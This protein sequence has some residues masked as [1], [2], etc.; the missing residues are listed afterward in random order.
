MQ[1]WSEQTDREDGADWA[2]RPDGPAYPAVRAGYPDD[3]PRQ[4]GP[5]DLRHRPEP[6]RHH[7]EPDWQDAPE[8]PRRYAEADWPME[9]R[10]Q[11]E[12]E[13]YGRQREPEQY[14]RQREP[15]QY[16]RQ[17]EPDWP[18]A[19]G[20]GRYPVDARWAD[21]PDG[22]AHSDA[23]WTGEPNGDPH[24]TDADWADGPDGGPQR[25][26]AGW[27]DEVTERWRRAGL[28]RADEPAG[29]RQEAAARWA[30]EPADLGA[31]EMGRDDDG[32]PVRRVRPDARDED[33]SR[34][35][36]SS[37]GRHRRRTPLRGPVG[38]GV[39]V[40]ALL[41]LL[42]VGA[43]LLPPSL[44]DAPAGNRGN[45]PAVEAAGP[46]ESTD[47][48]AEP[49]EVAEQ[50]VAPTPTATRAAPKPRV[51]T[52]APKP[53]RKT[54]S[55]P[56]RRT[57]AGSGSGSGA[58]GSSQEAQV[59]TIVNR[60][61][62]AEGCAAVVMNSDLTEAARLHSQDQ[63]EHTNMSHTGSDGSDFVERA[64]RAGYD[65]PIGENVA[66]GYENAAAVMDGW[67]KS[68]GHR[69]NILNCDAKA[70]GVGVATGADGRLYWTQ[71]FGA[72]A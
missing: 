47:P 24:P 14:G 63:G 37:S 6:A 56:V 2:S 55:P 15:E 9:D 33:D 57:P 45:Q 65:S 16:G 27:A 41:G 39:A 10:Q 54:S 66:M 67:M 72:V 32:G 64:R 26:E 29:R 13:Q 34:P 53:A 62:A 68:S 19:P 22:G 61:R 23:G 69:A 18:E 43:A 36:R 50:T 8:D 21:E 38:L 58:A 30:D 12:P 35:D 49:T 51:T 17:R 28:D 60:E 40:T 31:F 1:G 46:E 52:T 48:A 44:A 4:P 70:M 5:D 11:T 20:D 42:G 71:V 25:G 3:R 7:P 59:L